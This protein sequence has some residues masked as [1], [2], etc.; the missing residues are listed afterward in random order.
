MTIELS[1]ESLII[2]HA[3]VRSIHVSATSAGLLTLH[4]LIAHRPI[5]VGNFHTVRKLFA[6]CTF[7][8]N[9]KLLPYATSITANPG[10]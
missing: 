9:S 5:F 4:Y 10:R 6:S 1:N 2:S 3:P 7:H 8:Q